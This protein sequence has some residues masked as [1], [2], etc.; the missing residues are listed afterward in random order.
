MLHGKQTTK[1]F[2]GRGT[3]VL[4]LYSETAG[5]VA[6]YKNPLSLCQRTL[7]PTLKLTLFDSFKI[8][9]TL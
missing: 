3:K 4:N 7:V 9:L 5:P 1:I 2:K 8:S 6:S